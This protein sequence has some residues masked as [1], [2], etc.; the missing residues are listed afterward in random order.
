MALGA[1]IA[2]FIKILLLLTPFFVVS[3]FMTTCADMP[4]AAQRSLA[5]RTAMAVVSACL[6]LFFLGNIMFQYLGI[7]LDAFRIGAGVVLLLNGID[8]VRGSI[9]RNRQESG[10]ADPAIVPLAI[11]VTVGPGTIGA[12]L[13]MSVETPGFAEKGMSVLAIVLAGCCIGLML[14]YCNAIEHILKSKG[15]AILSRLTGMYIV[16]LAAQIIFTGIHKMLH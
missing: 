11:P 2:T 1:F 13:V 10:E 15:L 5:V 4:L 16:A 12:M 9:P 8:M 7:T 14:F 3:Y 6:L